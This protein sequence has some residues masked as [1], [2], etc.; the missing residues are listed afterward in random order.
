MEALKGD[1]IRIHK[2][3]LNPGERSPQVPED[4]GQVPLEMWDKGFLL[5]ERAR[6]GETVEVETIIGRRIQGTLIE[7]N[8]QYRHSYGDLIP[9]ILQI[10][11]QIRGILAD[12]E[13]IDEK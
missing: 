7:V 9:E 1:W 10:G 5:N 3:I 8:P 6:R 2:V 4:T 11:R 13:V 12:R